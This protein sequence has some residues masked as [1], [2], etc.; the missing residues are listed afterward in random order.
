MAKR[1][2]ERIIERAAQVPP[3][4]RT[5]LALLRSRVLEKDLMAAVLSDARLLGW[6]AYH[7][8]DSRRSEPGFPDAVLVRERVVW[9]EFKVG[10][11]VLS[12]AQERW[13]AALKAAGAEVYVLRPE[14]REWFREE[15]LR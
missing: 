8:H 1:A 9:V 2:W 12:A 3:E 14:Q 13:Q 10:R 4:E 15:V 5:A 11:G 7:T 6:L